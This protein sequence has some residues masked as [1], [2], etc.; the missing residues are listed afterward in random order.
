MDKR[1]ISLALTVLVILCTF[2]IGFSV[3]PE[4]A[5]GA[6]LY[7]GGTGPLNYTTIQEAVNDAMWWDTVYVY[8]GTYYEQVT[9]NIGISLVGEDRNTTI[10]NGSGVGRVIYVTSDWVTIRGF[11]ITNSSLFYSGIE[12]DHVM[13]CQISE[14]NISHNGAG[15]VIWSSDLIT[16]TGNIISNNTFGPG[17]WGMVSNSDTITNNDVY[18]NDGGGI[19]LAHSN[20][21]T[22]RNNN[23]SFNMAGIGTDSSHHATFAGN[24]ITSNKN[25]GILLAYSSYITVEWNNLSDNG[26]GFYLWETDNC[27]ISNNNASNNRG[28][29]LTSLTS[30]DNNIADNNFSLS[31][32]H[33]IDLAG[34]FRG[35][36]TNNTIFSPNNYGLF[37]WGSQYI[38]VTKNTMGG[39]GVQIGTGSGM[40]AHWNTHLIDTS[41]TVNGKPV[42]YWKNVTS[43]TV[44]LGAGQV[45]LANCTNV[46]IHNQSTVD[47]ST[48]ILIGFTSNSTI[49]DNNISENSWH[50]LSLQHSDSNTIFSNNISS[51][52]WYGIHLFISNSNRVYHNDFIDNLNQAYDDRATNVWDD[53]YPSGGN[54]WSDYMGVD[55]MSGPNQDIPGSDGI[56][57]TPYVIDAD[58]Q[59]EY[60]LMRC[61]SPVLTAP[62]KPQNLGAVGWNQQVNLTW[63]MPSSDGGSPITN[64]TI[65]RGTTPGGETLLT[66]VGNVL[67]HTDT[68]LTNGIT[69]FYQVAAVN[70]IGEGPRS[71]E[72]NATPSYLPSSP[73]KIQ[74]SPANQ[75]VKLDWNPPSSNGG[76]SVTNYRIY[77]G[78]ISGGETFLVEIGNITTHSDTGLTN[79]QTYYYQVSAV[80]GVGEGPLSTEVS[81]TPTKLPGS[82][83]I[84]SAFLGGKD[85]ENV[86]ITWSLSTDDGAGQNSVVSYEI[87][88]NL[89]YDPNG[90]GYQ[91]AGIVSNGTT[92]L[93][94]KFAGEGDPNNHFYRICA[95][96][97]NNFTSCSTN[98]AAKFTRS[99]SKGFNLLSIPLIQ[100]DEGIGAVLKTVSYE[101]IWFY[102]SVEQRWKSS[103]KSKPYSTGL[104]SLNHTVGFWIDVTEDSNLTVAGLVPSTTT[105]E[106]QAGWNL[107]GFPSFN[108]SYAIGD[109]KAQTGASRVEGSDS[110][111]S[112]YFLRAILDSEIMQTGVGYWVYVENPTA[113]ILDNT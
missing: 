90:L 27:L 32:R 71:S 23:V 106:L 89:T 45:I 34:S 113:W 11:T 43:G 49:V 18:L 96:D 78:D 5:R 42:H 60:P 2:Q 37:L 65:Y 30:Y 19:F 41:N 3:L 21:T 31:G 25:E 74:T 103:V 4:N 86:T 67:N 75:E 64:Y 59:D 13:N 70:S 9:I 48:G 85:S 26:K 105:I 61:I 111:V 35:I 10:I 7:V 101:R 83:V 52:N 72:A 62:S 57:D 46:I 15:I 99:L 63:N 81:A 28:D 80:N 69:Y 68:G 47:S 98:Q 54:C 53:G 29:G 79:G 12:L 24:N 56:G 16:I 39:A 88:D 50:G 1:K 109:L 84:L 22:F 38:I 8:S 6:T 77:R 104:E 58:S 82:P 95:V 100:S 112:P 92:E 20:W 87:Y 40:I 44:P 91:L 14:N 107:V 51:N 97:L 17:I 108:T 33:G 102:D 73:E 66:T 110:L 94:I 76:S 93:T 36:V 55:E